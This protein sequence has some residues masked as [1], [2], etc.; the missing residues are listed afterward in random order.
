MQI[1]L[2][3]LGY[4]VGA[5]DGMLGTRTQTAWSE[6][7]TDVHQGDPDML[8]PDSVRVLETMA[9]VPRAYNLAAKAAT[10]Q[11]IR[12][13][14]IKQGI[15]LN[16]Q[17]AYVLATVQWETN[18]TF[19]PVA[20]AYYEPNAE[21]WRKENLSYYPFYG[22]GYV[23]LT[24]KSNYEYYGTLLGVNLVTTPDLAMQPNNALFVL[25]HGFK[26]GVFTGR[27]ITD[28]IDAS[29][30]DFINARRCINGTDRAYE[31]ASLAEAYLRGSITATSA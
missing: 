3:I 9:R 27:S 21:E 14:C 30:T 25:V 17:V 22:R 8:G 5:L 16:A 6:F 24:W 1:G 12:T 2:A 31:I 29:H 26:T 4:P 11:A 19:E 23:Q 10:I 20:E 15:G 7:K 28:Y 13:E 18:A